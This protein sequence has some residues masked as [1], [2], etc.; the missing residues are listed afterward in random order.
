MN[1]IRRMIVCV[2]VAILCVSITYYVT[3]EA[4]D[5]KGMVDDVTSANGSSDVTK[6]I[7]DTA[8]SAIT[9]AQVIGVGVAVIMLIVLGMKYMI[10]APDDKAQIKKHAVVYIIGAVVLFGASGILQIIKNFAKVAN[11]D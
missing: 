2:I 1:I 6:P 5:W 8:K 9:I 3:S 7:E 4:K 11:N 10:S